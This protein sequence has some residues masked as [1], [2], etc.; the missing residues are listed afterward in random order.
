MT[1][2]P[3]PEF[4]PLP[5]VNLTARDLSMSRDD[6]PLFENLSL[7]LNP[8]RVQ[9]IEGP[10]GSGKTTL[11]RIMCGLILADE[12]DIEFN[13]Q[14]IRTARLEFQE[15]LAYLGHLHGIKEELTV[16]ENLTFMQKLFS[17][18]D[19]DHDLLALLETV[20]LAGFEYSP[21][22]TLSAGQRR[23]LGIARVLLSDAAIWVMD[24]PYTAMD[25]KG[26][27]MVEALI[28]AHCE[29]GGIALVTSH[30]SMALA[31]LSETPVLLG[32]Q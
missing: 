26:I 30:Q 1:T 24:E 15:Q 5:E 20:G 3:L 23:R 29:R 11:L 6:R 9:Q 19:S 14:N 13:G 22:R 4:R 17:S 21:A 31:H 2:I 18:Q 10:N 28:S 7:S 12:G 27:K 16:I 25:R 8:G 32:G